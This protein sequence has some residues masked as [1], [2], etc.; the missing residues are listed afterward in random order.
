MRFSK[1]WLWILG[2]IIVAFIIIALL[3]AFVFTDFLVDLWWFESLGYSSFFWQRLLYQYLVFILATALFFTLFYV[4]IWIASKFLGLALSHDSMTAGQ[5]R[6]KR[7]IKHF[8]RGSRAFFIPISLVLAVIIA[9][10][11]FYQ[12]EQTLLYVFAPDVGIKDPVYNNDI[13]YYLLALPIY[14]LILWELLIGFIVLFLGLFVLYWLEGRILSEYEQHLPVGARLHLSVLSLIIFLIGSGYFILQRHQLLYVEDHMPLF[15][16]PGFAE[17]NVTLPLIWACLITLIGVGLSLAYF[18]YRQKGL[19]IL[20]TFSVLFVIALGLRY[21]TFLPEVIQK[22]Y[23]EPNEIEVESPYIANNIQATL[24]AYDLLDVN[25]LEYP[26]K[27]PPWTTTTPAFQA[28]LRNA[29]IWDREVLEDVYDQLQTLRPYYVFPR[30]SVDSYTIEDTYQQVFLSPREINIDRLPEDAHTWVNKWLRYTHGTGVAMNPA[31]QGGEE[32]ITWFIQGIPPESEFGLSVEQPDIYYG[33]NFDHPVIAPNE[34][35]EFDYPTRDENV[36]TDYKGEGGV[37]IS[38]LFRRI[39]FALYFNDRNIFFTLQ[40]NDESR[41]LFRRNIIERIKKITPFLVLD[42]YPYAVVTP[43]RTYWIQDAYIYSDW[44]PYSRPYNK[45]LTVDYP[46]PR[47]YETFNY[48]RNSV[49]IIIDAYDGTVSYYVVEPNDPIIQAYRRIYP[50]LFK[51]FDEMPASLKAH[52]R[53]PKNLFDM[54]MDVYARYHQTHPHVFYNQEDIWTF[55]RVQREGETRTITSVYLTLNLIGQDN[56]EFLLLT[57][58]SPRGRDNL[59]AL[60]IARSDGDNYGEIFI[61]SFPEGVL[62]Y[63]PPQVEA[64]INQDTE[65]SAQFTL[66]DQ[67]GSEVTRGK[68]IILPVGGIIT[69]IQPVYLVAADP[70]SFPQ[71]K[72]IIISQGTSV[73]MKTTLQ[74][75]FEALNEELRAE[76]EPPQFEEIKPPQELPEVAPEGPSPDGSP[77]PSQ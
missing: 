16:G 35:H 22:E 67:A 46:Y 54:Q 58:M 1:R 36:L 26:I 21:T 24:A 55:P 61:Y 64:L 15:F 51:D 28:A 6:Y 49:K 71:L 3:L 34:V 52:V 44:Y 19:K 14:L 30:I 63:G 7:M 75:G 23:V 69:Y 56:T 73:V 40:I 48:I 70:V 25:I 8:K 13:S 62:V 57:P 32:P 33:F 9:W 39:V 11:L 18:I 74:E 59:N 37:P 65:I 47:I 43:E 76:Q 53:Y 38:N 10:P 45:Q 68:M 12:W 42:E 5:Q 17:M 29:P 50:G 60:A 66:W 72:R 31:A 4:N 2:S 27:E 41:I 77:S 20:I